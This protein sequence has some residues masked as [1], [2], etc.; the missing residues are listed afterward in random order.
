MGNLLNWSFGFFFGVIRLLGL[1]LIGRGLFTG[2]LRLTFDL[3][4]FLKE[5]HPG[6]DEDFDQGNSVFWVLN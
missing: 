2:T 5:E 3:V 1:V 4:L 6:V